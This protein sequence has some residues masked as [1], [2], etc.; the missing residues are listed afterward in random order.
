MFRKAFSLT[1]KSNIIHQSCEE[2]L[3]REEE[4]N[5]SLVHPPPDLSHECLDPAN[6][7]EREDRICS[8]K[9][10]SFWQ[11]VQSGQCKIE[12]KSEFRHIS[13]QAT[14]R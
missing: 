6:G 5:N 1:I 14:M 12:L 4:Y 3:W 7:L 10:L 2:N 8:L 11:T 13:I 9:L